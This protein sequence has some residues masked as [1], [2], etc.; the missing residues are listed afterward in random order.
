MR[1]CTKAS[2]YCR[3]R[4]LHRPFPLKDWHV[5]K[6]MDRNDKNELSQNYMLIYS[7]KMSAIRE[8]NFNYH[9]INKNNIKTYLFW[10]CC[11][12]VLKS[13]WTL[14]QVSLGTLWTSIF[15]TMRVYHMTQ[16][17]CTAVTRELKGRSLLKTAPCSWTSMHTEGQFK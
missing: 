11:W 15:A 7:G 2:Q 16:K 5:R 14:F 10:Y 8:W 13:C 9:L 1:A 3:D 4:L 12:P 6:I 17:P